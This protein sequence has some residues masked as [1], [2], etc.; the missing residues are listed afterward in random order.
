MEKRLFL[1]MIESK[2]RR[3]AQELDEWT[4]VKDIPDVGYEIQL[5]SI[6][7]LHLQLHIIHVRV[8]IQCINKY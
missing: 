6:I 1:D 5:N 7:Y 3:G 2:M 8:T 4:E